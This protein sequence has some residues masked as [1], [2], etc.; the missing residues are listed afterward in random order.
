MR[1]VRILASLIGMIMLFSVLSAGVAF[2]DHTG[3]TEWT[4]DAGETEDGEGCPGSKTKDGP[5][6]ENTLAPVGSHIGPTASPDHPGFEN[7][8]LNPSGNAIN[9]INNNPLCPFHGV[10]GP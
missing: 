6:A 1:R 7:G 4:C 9:A 2:A 3:G 10:D 8:F 5:A